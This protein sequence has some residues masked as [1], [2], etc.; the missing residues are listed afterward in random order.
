MG[1]VQDMLSILFMRFFKGGGLGGWAG[2]SFNSLYEI[3]L[4]LRVE[5][6]ECL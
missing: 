5:A 4:P 3:L 2:V 1:N 6:G